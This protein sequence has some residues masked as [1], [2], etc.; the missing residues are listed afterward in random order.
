MPCKFFTF[1]C[2]NL[3]GL[4]LLG[5]I[6]PAFDNVSFP[7]FRGVRL[8]NRNAK[9]AASPAK[10]PGPKRKYQAEVLPGPLKCIG[11]NSVNRLAGA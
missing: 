4:R 2:E 6:Q 7:R 3:P 9:P 1:C 8:L 5:A 11:F 10:R